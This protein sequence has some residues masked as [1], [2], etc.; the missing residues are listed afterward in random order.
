MGIP[1]ILH[2][3][4]TSLD[5]DWLTSTHTAPA[6]TELFV[7][8]QTLQEVLHVV[9]GIVKLTQWDPRGVESIV[10]FT[11]AGEWLGTAAVIAESP[12]PMSAVT[13][14]RTALRRVSARTF[15]DQ[16]D[17]N[18]QLSRQI[19]EAHSRE[20]CRQTQWIGQL[21]S[22]GSLQR[23]RC[24]LCRLAEAA[25]GTVSGSAVR[26]QLPIHRWELAEFIGVTPEHLSR[27]LKDMER[28]DLIRRE[29]GWIVIRDFTRL[30]REDDPQSS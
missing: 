16:L 6:G 21:C 19:H 4:E 23:L 24:A 22:L 2:E 12:T 9:S 28:R 18:R 26:L 11:F 20:L 1:A 27:L 13:C 8:G 17:H 3:R 14:C 25:Q 5:A 29:K 10:G 7:Q 15:R 30:C